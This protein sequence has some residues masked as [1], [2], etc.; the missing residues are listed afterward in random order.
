MRRI[1][2]FKG[3]E[4]NIVHFPGRS[5][6]EYYLWTIAAIN[7][8]KFDCP[9]NLTII[10]TSTDYSKSVISQ[11]LNLNSVPFIN[12]F[13][14]RNDLSEGFIMEKKVEYIYNA[15]L[16]IKTEFCLIVDAYDSFIYDLSTIIDK[17][18]KRET[19]ILFNPTKNNYP[20]LNIDKIPQ[21]DYLGEFNHLN[22]G[23][24]IGYT[25]DLTDFYKECVDFRNSPDYF[26]FYRSEQ[27]IIRSIFA[28]HSEHCTEKPCYMTFDYD[29]NIFA[30]GVSALFKIID[31]ETRWIV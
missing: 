15:L 3:Q 22:A 28:K 10:L 24:V 4:V 29:C 7:Q 18:K 11:Q 27:F 30:T 13:D 14:Y 23:N 20:S 17:F 16:N 2:N 31:E 26:N 19:R 5:S 25:K 21:R 8:C 6:R 9:E 1:L 12:S